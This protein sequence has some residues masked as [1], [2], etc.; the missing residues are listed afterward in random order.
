MSY[1]VLVEVLTASGCG[2]CK[3]AKA[4]AKEVIAQI[5]AENTNTDIQY[6]EI[7]VVDAIDYAVQLGVM[8]TPAIALNGELVFAAQ[9]SADK[10]HQAIRVRLVSES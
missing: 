9:P 10:L 6:R 3:Q 5:L 2:R 4:L 7:N 8:S 1:T